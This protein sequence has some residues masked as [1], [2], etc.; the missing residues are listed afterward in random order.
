[1]DESKAKGLLKILSM[2]GGGY[3][4]FFGFLMIFLIQP[5]FNLLGAAITSLQFPIFSQ[6]GGLLAIILCLIDLIFA[7]ITIYLIRK[8]NLSF[9]IFKIVTK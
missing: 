4:V 9:N 2:I 8:S 7:I 3:E 1:M 5:L 6:T